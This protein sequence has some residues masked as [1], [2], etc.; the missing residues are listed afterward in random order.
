MHTPLARDPAVQCSAPVTRLG[1]G[2]RPGPVRVRGARK[3]SLSRQHQFPPASDLTGLLPEGPARPSRFS[4]RL[5]KWPRQGWF[6]GAGKTERMVRRRVV[7][8]SAGTAALDVL[9]GGVMAR[10]MMTLRDGAGGGPKGCLAA[11]GG[12]IRPPTGSA[13]GEPGDPGTAYRATKL[14]LV[15]PG[16]DGPPRLGKMRGSGRVSA[17]AAFFGPR[18]RGYPAAVPGRL[19]LAPF[20]GGC[21]GRGSPGPDRFLIS[22][23]PPCPIPG[24][25]LTGGRYLPAAPQAGRGEAR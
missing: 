5:A 20:Y 1:T 10:C 2:W 13:A 23:V 14:R 22:I 15:M 8:G 9:T 7:A 12:R 18:S 19:S 24:R 4:A 21:G 17:S 16:G 3:C 25:H 6:S 11:S